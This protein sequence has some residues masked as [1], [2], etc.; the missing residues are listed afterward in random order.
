MSD[1]FLPFHPL[2][3]IFP[4]M[5]GKEFDELVD[6]IKRRG[7]LFPI[8]TFNGQIIDGR[9]RARACDKAGVKPRYTP[10]KG[11]EKDIPR[12]IISANILRRHLKPNERRD[13]IKK[14]LKLN[15]EASDRT[16]GA[17]AKADHKTVA[18]VRREQE[19]TGEIPRLGKRV[20]QD[21]K[22]RIQPRK[23]APRTVTLA[24][25]TE[26]LGPTYER[27]R[28]TSL[29]ETREL[30]A[31]I[32]L[33]EAPADVIN[34]RSAGFDPTHPRVEDL[35]ARAERGE[36]V[37]AVAVRAD[38]KKAP[39]ITVHGLIEG[40]KHCRLFPDWRRADTQVRHEFINYLT[41][42]KGD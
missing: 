9:N 41:Q 16:V 5:E 25:R 6:D 27:I 36:A 21:G 32:E 10:F 2:A 37:S 31:L 19:A 29:D 18:A 28:G 22:R 34:G 40:W 38:L 30:A 42:D 17:M 4:L 33:G 35:L 14:I 1:K 15:P 26:K 23:K 3:D 13:L 39:P 24:I 8:T 20:G 7:L 11:S 12:F